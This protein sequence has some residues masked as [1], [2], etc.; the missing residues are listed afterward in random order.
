MH[1][2]VL[3]TSNLAYI[4]LLAQRRISPKIWLSMCLL[5]VRFAKY[6]GKYYEKCSSSWFETIA[7]FNRVSR[8][9][10]IDVDRDVSTAILLV[11]IRRWC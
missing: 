11:F 7:E 3:K 1:R 4:M 8:L 6:C 2:K 9:S 10:H 5:A